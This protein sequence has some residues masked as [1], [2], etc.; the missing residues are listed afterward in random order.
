MSPPGSGY[1]ERNVRLNA[2]PPAEGPALVSPPRPVSTAPVARPDTSSRPRRRPRLGV[3]HVSLPKLTM[4]TMYDE[5]ACLRAGLVRPGRHVQRAS[6]PV[7]SLSLFTGRRSR[8]GAIQPFTVSAIDHGR[9]ALRPAATLR[10]PMIPAVN[11]WMRTVVAPAAERHLGTAV[12]AMRVA[13]SYGCR[14]IN[15]RSGNKLSQHA[16]ANA[17]DISA[18]TLADGRVVTVKRGWHGERGERAFL[19]SVHRGACDMFTTVLG[20]NADR[21][22]R[23][24]FHFDLAKHT[25]DGR[26]R[27]CK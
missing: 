10:C 1:V 23:D 13:A 9:V 12:V 7:P 5:R 25:S 15:S 14:T 20:P 2:M 19:R 11:R 26:Y 27:L 17:L 22:H 18:F 21:F 24:H 6:A 3:R 8:C 16:Y 4:A